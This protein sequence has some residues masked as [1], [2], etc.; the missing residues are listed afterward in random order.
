L[1]FFIKPTI[2]LWSF[3]FSYYFSSYFIYS[4]FILFHISFICSTFLNWVLVYS[5][6]S[7]WWILLVLLSYLVYQFYF[8]FLSL[9]AS[10]N[11][12]SN[13][14][15]Y[16]KK[17]SDY[18]SE[19]LI[20]LTSQTFVHCLLSAY[21][22]GDFVARWPCKC[23]YLDT[24]F[25]SQQNPFPVQNLPFI[26]HYDLFR[27]EDSALHVLDI[28][29]TLLQLYHWSPLVL[30]SWRNWELHHIP[31]PKNYEILL[32]LIHLFLHLG[33]V[34]ITMSIFNILI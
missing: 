1:T 9:L 30:F 5:L 27:C 6:P 14:G 7:P 24:M 20:L 3:F 29:R 25:P 15:P 17:R 10:L 18:I 11:L 23:P 12:Q 26:F 31:S 19:T 8:S 34:L 2:S 4:F 21:L 22:V 28:N 16:W 33:H 13:F 32:W